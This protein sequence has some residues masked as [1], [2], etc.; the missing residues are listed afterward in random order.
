MKD[1]RVHWED[2]IEED[3][4]GMRGGEGKG[5]ISSGDK[6]MVIAKISRE[7]KLGAG[8]GMWRRF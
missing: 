6:R 7:P 4:S 2:Q 3:K 1:K 5:S 8:G